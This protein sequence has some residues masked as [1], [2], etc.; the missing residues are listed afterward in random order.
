MAGNITNILVV[1]DEPD[2]LELLVDALAGPDQDVTT[3]A[4][5]QQA[6]SVAESQQV[7][8]V[9]ADLYL[10]DCTGLEVIDRLRGFCGDLPAI[11]ITGSGDAVGLSEASR[12]RPVELMTKPLDL[13]RLRSTIRGEL[14]SRADQQRQARR[15]RRLRRLARD[16]NLQRKSIRHDLDD[17]CANLTTAYQSL[18][19]QM[20]LQKAVMAYQNS[21]LMAKNDDAVF[22]SLFR[23]F[24]HRSGPTFGAAMICDSNSRLNTV[25]RFGVPYPDSVSF[26][27]ALADP[28]IEAVLVTPECIL[29]DAGDQADKFDSSIHR[30]LPG[31]SILAMPLMP[32]I[33]ELIGLVVMYRKG[34]QPFMQA[35]VALAEQIA[36]P[37]AL[38]VRRND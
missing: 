26:C 18:S 29:I 12:R 32:S 34:E 9:V 16:A 15:T 23:L 24:V 33:G 6:I 3:A 20:S 30:Y 37:T 8:F 31:L 21:L 7:D 25:G 14:A 13:A 11:V 19:S 2:L 1:D 10:G 22:S 17:T 36:P 38:A 28:L 35:D 4:S 5:G 27:E